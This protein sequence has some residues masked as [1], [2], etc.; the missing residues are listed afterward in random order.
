[1]SKI[2][3]K[4]RRYMKLSERFYKVDSIFLQNGDYD[5]TVRMKY[6]RKRASKTRLSQVG[7]AN[8]NNARSHRSLPALIL[9]F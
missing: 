8:L 7:S 2:L 6:G 4:A 3:S 5:V 1:M 9:R